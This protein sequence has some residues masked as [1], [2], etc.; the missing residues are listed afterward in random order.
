VSNVVQFPED[1]IHR[2]RLV[3]ST[4]EEVEAAIL[5]KKMEYIQHV[6]TTEMRTL[7]ERLG[8]LHGLDNCNPAI[9]QDYAMMATCL[10]SLISRNY[11]IYHPFQDHA[12][13]VPQDSVD[14]FVKN[15]AADDPEPDE[16]MR[17]A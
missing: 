1:K 2:D 3:A 16:P 8:N 11:D 15:V 13:K 4:I 7:F 10:L 17:F 6:T 12:D 14:D 9:Y 5:S